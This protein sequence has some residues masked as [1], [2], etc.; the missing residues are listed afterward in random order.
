MAARTL[1]P[2]YR[3]ADGKEANILP[4]LLD[5]LAKAYAGR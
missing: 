5:M 4:G 3:D 1:C 2:L